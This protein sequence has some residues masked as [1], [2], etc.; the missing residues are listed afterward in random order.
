MAKK[1]FS[2]IA[3]F[4]LLFTSCE[5]LNG[6]ETAPTG[7]FHITSK[8][9]EEVVAEGGCFTVDYVIDEAVK[10]AKVAATA[11]V[12]W[13][14]NITVDEAACSL[15]FCVKKNEGEARTTTLDITYASA[16]QTITINQE[17]AAQSNIVLDTYTSNL[18]AASSC[19]VVSYT[20]NT[21]IE[22][23]VIEFTPSAEWLYISNHDAENNEFSF[24]VEKNE[25]EART[26]TIDVTYAGE[27]AVI[28]VNQA[29][30]TPA[31][32]A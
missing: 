5:M 13:V 9:T 21:V 1:F 12:D 32:E 8:T 10:G 27:T 28:T 23:A 19:I 26:A 15:T 17:A 31:V 11:A 22:G 16:K 30:G 29:A 7:K 18:D 6:E 14:Y 20:I 3:A 25:S 4:A 24:C 2:A